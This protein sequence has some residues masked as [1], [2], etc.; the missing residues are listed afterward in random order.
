MTDEE[1]KQI[2]SDVL[3][4][5]KQ[6]STTI[7]QMLEKE[8]CA[9]DDF[10]E[11][12]KGNKI[13][14]KTLSKG[15][16]EEQGAV[17]DAVRYQLKRSDGKKLYPQTSSACVTMSD[18]D[19]SLDTRVKN[20]TTEYN[21]S[22]F[23]PTS[24]VNGSNK[25]TLE[26]AIVQVPSKY[27]N[28]GI[29][30]AFLNEAGKLES[31]KYQGGTFTTITNWEKIP[32]QNQI[33]ILESKTNIKF[34]YTSGKGFLNAN[35]GITYS[36]SFYY[37]VTPIYYCNKG[38]IF[39]YKGKGDN[40]AKSY[41]FLYDG[42][43]KQSFVIDSVNSYT[44]IEIPQ[45]VNGIIFG[46]YGSGS[47]ENVILDVESSNF[48]PS[49]KDEDGE[50]VN[51]PISQSF[52]TKKTNGI[53]YDLEYEKNYIEISRIDGY[54]NSFGSVVSGSQ[55]SGITNKIPVSIGD[56]FH[57]VGIRQS[58]SRCWVAYNKDNVVI[59]SDIESTYFTQ[60]EFDVEVKEEWAYIKFSSINNYAQGLKFEVTRITSKEITLS[61]LIMQNSQK[62]KE[63][64]NA[65][66]D[67]NKKKKI[68]RGIHFCGHSIWANNGATYTQYSPFRL[69]GYQTRILNEFSFNSTQDI[70]SSGKTIKTLYEEKI[71]LL[72]GNP[73][74][75]Y[76]IDT[77]TNDAWGFSD[78]QIGTIDDYDNNTGL[79]T[80]YG[81]LRMWVDKINSLTE[82]NNIIVFA[83]M[84]K[85]QSQISSEDNT[86]YINKL[87]KIFNATL[88]IAYK[89]NAYYVD[90][91]N[92]VPITDYNYRLCFYDGS[93]HLNNYGY[94][95]AVEPWLDVLN[96]IYYKDIYKNE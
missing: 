69:E 83:N 58:A 61:D 54:M 41:L 92:L 31:W 89:I 90:Q 48:V 84:C 85:T 66:V 70:S 64:E 78:E 27:R 26:T 53:S 45:D 6:N 51:N 50:S 17:G 14:F 79:D 9:D 23:H 62:I 39:K 96:Q 13:S 57:Y 24:G 87:H 37:K 32:N 1:R 16:N 22:L 5:L 38:D 52:F 15:F 91:N 20:I 34:I 25:Y 2:V 19:D 8:N 46:S 30:C 93:T 75:I 18:G 71:S 3:A 81:A 60:V 12:N 7:D 10:F 86:E 59:E 80:Y 11:T 28:V 21:V 55:K 49:V 82:N 68:S 94:Q 56:K 4:A 63:I 77:N 73:G 35:G 33:K 65:G 72:T 44:E 43:V 74:D 88:E 42:I 36:D 47:V 67:I 95:I 40:L 76:L 29:K